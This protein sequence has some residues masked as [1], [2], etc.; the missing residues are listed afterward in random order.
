MI[1][2]VPL[3]KDTISEVDL[4]RMIE[5]LRTNPRLTKG[6]K[7]VEFEKAWSAWNG[8]K[9]SVFVSSGSAA[10]LAA[11]YALMLSGRMKNKRVI[12]PAV[13]WATTVAPA[14]QLGLD[15]ILCDCN[16][17]NLGLD[18]DH[19]NDLIKLHD[20]AVIVTVNVLGFANDYDKILELCRQKNILL[21]EDSCESIGTQ[22]MGRKV[23]SFGDISTFSF[24]YGHHMSTIEGGMICTNDHELDQIIKSIRCH[25]WD[26]DLDLEKQREL[27]DAHEIDDFKALYTFY[28]PGFNLRC[29]DLQAFI[30]LEQMKKIDYIV[31]KRQKNFKIYVDRVSP[32]WGLDVSDHDVVSNFTFPVIT[33]DVSS[34]V[35]ALRESSI[36]S[37]P[38]ICGSI[39]RQPF[40]YTRYG[41]STFKNADVV[42]DFGLYVPNNPDM[43]VEE[44][45]EVASL[46][47]S[48]N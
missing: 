29:T 32:K 40:W 42:H 31:D 7:T 37:R 5:W 19:L 41:K 3:V 2:R 20:P 33:K 4:E 28:Y 48:V 16:L 1:Y 9:H 38:L 45:E 35:S 34:L 18:I 47:C 21:I 25:G 22:Y 30:G 13:S 46:I 14:I 43:T 44:V 11:Y 8:F 27:R 15:P 24:Y 26:R 6:E 12:V 17:R 36:E 23:G 39:S 10:N